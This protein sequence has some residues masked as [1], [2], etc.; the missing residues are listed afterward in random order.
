[1]ST[2]CLGQQSTAPFLPN[3]LDDLGHDFSSTLFRFLSLTCFLLLLFLQPN[4]VAVSA[5]DPHTFFDI[6][7]ICLVAPIHRILSS[8]KINVRCFLKI[9]KVQNFE[10]TFHVLQK[11]QNNTY[12][13]FLPSTKFFFLL[14][15]SLIDSKFFSGFLPVSCFDF[16]FIGCMKEISF[17][18]S[19]W[20]VVFSNAEIWWVFCLL[21]SLT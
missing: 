13:F 9:K 10:T 4:I 19:S 1:M 6:F 21:F 7:V 8:W 15:W 3:P 17:L 2:S 12:T 20:V 18:R 16:H 5:Q 14:I 11:S